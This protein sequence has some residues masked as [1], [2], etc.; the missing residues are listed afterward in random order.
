MHGWKPLFFKVLL[1]LLSFDVYSFWLLFP[2]NKHMNLPQRA[3]KLL[4]CSASQHYATPS[5]LLHLSPLACLNMTVL[6]RLNDL[7]FSD[8]VYQ[9]WL[10]SMLDHMPTPF[11]VS[12]TSWGR[13]AVHALCFIF[14]KHLLPTKLLK[15]IF[16]RLSSILIKE[17]SDV[18]SATASS[19]ETTYLHWCKTFHWSLEVI[20]DLFALH[21][22]VLSASS[23][24]RSQ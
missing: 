7:L 24:T 11:N 10:F 20:C 3:L 21:I 12:L 6:H 14:A 2:L 19:D 8:E 13:P 15:T 4:K 23:L 18:S 9:D 22:I 16:Y 5:T 17:G 1:T